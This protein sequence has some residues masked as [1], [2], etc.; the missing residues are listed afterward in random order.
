MAKKYARKG[1]DFPRRDILITPQDELYNTNKILGGKYGKSTLTPT[2]KTVLRQPRLETTALRHTQ[3]NILPSS[4]VVDQPFQ[5]QRRQDH[6]DPSRF[7]ECF[8]IVETVNLPPAAAPPVPTTIIQFNTFPT[9]R[10][11]IRW[12]EFINFD[13]LTPS[14]ITVDVTFNGQPVKSLCQYQNL[15]AHAFPVPVGF[16]PQQTPATNTSIDLDGLP[17][18]F[19]N[20]LLEIPDTQIVQVRGTNTLPANRKVQAA[21]WGWIEPIT[22]LSESIH[23]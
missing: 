1:R 13:G 7:A 20:I 18:D 12:I 10:S 6:L 2:G 21:V 16:P 4:I 14:G 15:A 11:I 22:R 17:K 3:E 19:H 9:M 8:Y 5:T 23:K